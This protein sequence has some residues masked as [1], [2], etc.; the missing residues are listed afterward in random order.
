MYV[1]IENCEGGFLV[2]VRADR[3]DPCSLVIQGKTN[4]K[5]VCTSYAEVETYVRELFVG[6]D[7]KATVQDHGK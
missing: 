5:K 7:A 2:E 4:W 6:K 3:A 1:S